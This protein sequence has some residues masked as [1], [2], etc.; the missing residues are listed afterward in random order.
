MKRF[1]VILTTAVVLLASCIKN[2]LP[3]PLAVPSVTSLNAEGAKAVRID[4]DAQSVVIE[5]LETTDIAD[6]SITSVTLSEGAAASP[7]IAGR[8]DMR[9]PFETVITTWQDY[10]WRFSATQ[11]IERWFTVDGQVGATE[12]DP[13]NHRA[14]ARVS[15]SVEVTDVTVRSMKLGPEGISTYSRDIA[16]MHDFTHGISVDVTAHGRSEEWHLF[17]EQTET[18]VEFKSVSPWTRVAWLTAAGLADE[19]NG[20]R[21]RKTGASSWTVITD[22]ASDGGTFTAVAEGLEPETSYECVAFSGENETE[23]VAFVTDPDIQLPNAGFEVFSQAES[24][25][26]WSLYDAGSADPSLMTKWWDS[27]NAGSTTVGASYSICTP[28]LSDFKEGHASIRM[29]SRNVVIKFAAGNMFSGEFAGVM[30]TQGGK[31]NF[32]RPFTCRPR[33]LRL[34]AKYVSGVIDCMGSTPDDDP[35]KIGDKDRGTVYVALGDWD[36]RRYGGTPQ[37]PV[38]VNTTDKSTF[39]RSDSENVIAYGSWV[40]S[41]STEGW[42][43]IDIPLVYTSVTRKPTHI[44]VSCAASALGDYFTGSSQSILWVDDMRLVY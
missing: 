27:G 22:V 23:A 38:Q 26:Y 9:E 21:Y 39:F 43:E 10:V 3:Y 24:K 41:E 2:D 6:V 25:N 7:S 40:S 36:Y 13:V 12:I 37:S 30:G 32:G 18:L 16:D 17:V 14:I 44:I 28:D 1:A 8:H 31:V 11:E 35:V 20:F 15:Q 42:V 29:N 5:L 34:W 19:Q 4:Q 33:S